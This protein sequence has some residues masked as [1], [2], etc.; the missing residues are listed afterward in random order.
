MPFYQ[1]ESRG[2]QEPVTVIAAGLPRCIR[3]KK[4]KSVTSRIGW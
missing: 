4:S 2:D 1:S 3:T